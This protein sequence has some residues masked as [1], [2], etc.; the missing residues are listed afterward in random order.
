MVVLEAYTEIETMLSYC[1]SLLDDVHRCPCFFI[2]YVI[3]MLREKI[4]G[5]LTVWLDMLG[6]SQT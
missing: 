4:I 2:N 1:G 3:L 5:L 6:I